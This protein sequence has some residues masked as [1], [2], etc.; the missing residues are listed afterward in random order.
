MNLEELK[1]RDDENSLL[2]NKAFA[3]IKYIYERQHVLWY[4]KEEVLNEM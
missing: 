3:C 4:N 1:H 2:R